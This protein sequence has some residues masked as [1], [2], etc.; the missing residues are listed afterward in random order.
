MSHPE[1]PSTIIV[2]ELG[3]DTDVETARAWRRQIR[4]D[5]V[6]HPP[7]SVIRLLVDQTGY[8]PTSLTAHRVVRKVVPELLAA[9]G[10]SPALADLFSHTAIDVDAHPSVRIEACAMVHHDAV[11]MANLDR[12]LGR[13]SQRFFSDR[14]RAQRWLASLQRS[15]LAACQR[16]RARPSRSP[17]KT[18]TP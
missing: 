18:T 6:R 1:H 9:H 12:V 2:S 14:P 10:L 17:G 11:N 7:G 8:R 4:L 3:G 15:E 5:V 13:P 16:D